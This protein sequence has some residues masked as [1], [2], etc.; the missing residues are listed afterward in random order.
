MADPRVPIV[1]H[2]PATDAGVVADFS[3]SGEMGAAYILN[4]G[5]DPVYI[6]F[7]AVPANTDG[8]GR[9]LLPN[10]QSI[11]LDDIRYTT[12]GFRCTAAVTTEVDVIGT[13]RS[14]SSGQG[15]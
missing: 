2:V 12:I 11:N 13:P 9:F 3:A 7:D 6:A 1:L 15:F 4:R 5:G 10:G 14:G 8:D